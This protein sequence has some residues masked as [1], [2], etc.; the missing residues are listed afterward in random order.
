LAI[1][2]PVPSSSDIA[3]VLIAKSLARLPLHVAL[4][5]TVEQVYDSVNELGWANLCGKAVYHFR[6]RIAN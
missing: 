3:W 1:G 5:L 2:L 6:L 4:P